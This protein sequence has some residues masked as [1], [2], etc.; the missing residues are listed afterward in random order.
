MKYDYVSL[1]KKCCALG[2]HLARDI[3]ISIL[4]KHTWDLMYEK[5]T[6]WIQLHQSIYKRAPF[7]KLHQ[8][9]EHL[10]CGT[11]LFVPLAYLNWDLNIVLEEG[12]YPC[13]IITGLRMTYLAPS[14]LM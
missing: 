2:I 9:N 5:E 11:S 3:S 13:C 10:I 8:Q 7:C 4:A 6:L 1:P 12:I 14:Y